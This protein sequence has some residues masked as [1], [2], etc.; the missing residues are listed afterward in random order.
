MITHRCIGSWKLVSFESKTPD[1]RRFIDFV[2]NPA[3]KIALTALGTIRP[4]AMPMNFQPNAPVFHPFGPRPVGHLIYTADGYYA[5]NMGSP[6]RKG[7]GSEDLATAS[8][9]AQR[10]AL[11]TY[12]SSSGRFTVEGDR[13]L[14]HVE[15]HLY[16]DEVGRDHPFTLEF[17]ERGRMIALKPTAP[18]ALFGGRSVLTYATWERG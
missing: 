8:F 15:A 17:E 5:L 1:G 3:L 6:G 18:S 16:P 2:T 10:N 9:L 11:M 14:H 13:I 7:F 12:I 4:S